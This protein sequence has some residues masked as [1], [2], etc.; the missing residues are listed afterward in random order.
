MQT[1]ALP[2]FDIPL[3][4]ALPWGGAIL[5]A[6]LA[7]L[8]G[9]M[10]SN[11]T[12]LDAT[13]ELR[14]QAQERLLAGALSDA[15][16]RLGE[17]SA[18]GERRGAADAAALRERL[19]NLGRQQDGL[20]QTLNALRGVL[21]NKQARG[22]FGE[23]QLERLVADL[24]PASN[25]SLQATL[26][27]YRV[28]CL[29]ALPWPP[30][31]VPIDAKFPLE[32]FQAWRSAAGDSKM[33]A[34]AL[35]RFQ[36]DVATH[37]DAIASKYIHAGETAD[38]ALMFLPSEAIFAALHSDCRNIVEM[39]QRRRV[40]AVSPSTLWPL[41]N[42]LSGVLRDVRFA[43]NA[44][45]MQAAARDLANDSRSLADLTAKAQRD[46]SRLGDDLQALI[47]K[48]DALALAGQAFAG[49]EGAV[50]SEIDPEATPLP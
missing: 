40:F 41:L 2:Y 48:A 13:L 8:L 39:A 31:P 11:R 12:R 16:E 28:D 19:L 6:L 46:W 9:R 36:R 7:F 32:G 4:D 38:F 17:R 50:A 37:V 22:A 10:R 35:K 47:T 43:E 15:I 33:A 20:G 24:L 26:G 29:I 27:L 5:A 18:A 44:A 34:S 23:A 49:G 25:Y 42:T 3:A 21:D 1:I 45:A 14:L 30:G